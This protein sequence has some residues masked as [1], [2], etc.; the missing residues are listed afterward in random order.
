MDKR[1]VEQEVPEEHWRARLHE[2]IFE[3]DTPAGKAFDV[4]L[5]VVI[6]ASVAAVM[7]ESIAP[8]RAAH[9]TALR[10]AEW[11]FTVLF[12][13]E[14]VLRLACVR[15]PLAY[16]TSFFGVVDLL[17]VLPTYVSLVLPGTQALIVVRAV[18][19]LRIFRIFKI[20]RYVHELT[21]LVRAVRA[22]RAKIAVFLFAILSATLVLGTAMYVV[23][24]EASGFT[25]IPRAVYWAIVTVTTVGY[26][27]LA[28][29]TP[30]GQALAAFAMVLGYSLIIIPTGIFSAELIQAA[31]A[32]PTTQAC[33]ACSREG[34]DADA[35]FCKHCGEKL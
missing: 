12:T 34:H 9:G 4:A 32:G 16:A 14:Y 6:L 19:L 20:A 30:F 26:G 23:E 3:A 33:S 25:S 15:R 10:A 13:I 17:A 35:T 7:L 11:A 31:R 29:R 24:G 8:I 2:I 27:D 22:T 28:P 1:Q 5:L 18:R 21:A